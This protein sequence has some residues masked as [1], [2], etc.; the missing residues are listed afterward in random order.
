MA[1]PYT[2]LWWGKEHELEN[3]R[4]VPEAAR[5]DLGP[6]LRTI[7]D[8]ATK[9]IVSLELDL[10]GPKRITF[11]EVDSNYDYAGECSSRS[12]VHEYLTSSEIGGRMDR[13]F[14]TR[15]TGH[16]LVHSE[17]AEFFDDDTIGERA[18]DEGIA[19]TS[20]FIM[21]NPFPTWRSRG[22][23]VIQRVMRLPR[24]KI[25]EA[26]GELA[27]VMNS[28]ATYGSH[29]KRWMAYQKNP[30]L[31]LADIVGV[32]AVM[33]RVHEGHK[34]AELIEMPPAQVLGYE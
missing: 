33:A 6:K 30:D 1:R 22:P 31:R 15:V 11:W 12:T 18:A 21:D 29:S 32:A 27:D 24:N 20:S 5:G 23:T 13:G 25:R 28:S 17:R 9:G 8:A 16:E 2:E 26:L 14:R 4:P 3:I 19:I 10:H 7:L 34:I